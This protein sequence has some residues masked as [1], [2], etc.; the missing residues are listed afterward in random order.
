MC[1]FC[2]F[3]KRRNTCTLQ[4]KLNL[5][6]LVV[7]YYFQWKQSFKVMRRIY[8]RKFFK[9]INQ[10]FVRIET[11]FFCCFDQALYCCTGFCACYARK[12][13]MKFHAHGSIRLEKGHC[14]TMLQYTFSR[15]IVCLSYSSSLSGRKYVM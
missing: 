11:V 2:F 14:F 3:S 4:R 15:D 10:V 9:Y 5:L 7:L 12:F 13:C 1:H 8:E 6:Y